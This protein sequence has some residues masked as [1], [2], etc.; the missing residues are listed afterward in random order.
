MIL[1]ISEK[2]IA[3]RRIA[4][5]L[6]NGNFKEKKESG[7][8]YF[9]FK[10][11]NKDFMV[12]P[13]SGHIMNVRFE[14]GFS[15]WSINTLEKLTNAKI[16][17]AG[18]QKRIIS[19]IKKKIPEADEII[20]ATDADRE[21][22]SIGFEVLR[23][24]DE[25]NKKI[26]IKRATFSAITKEDINAAFSDLGKVNENIASSADARREID[27]IW[28]AVLT[29]FL[30]VSSKR[31]GKSFLSAGRVQSPVLS[32][33]V[34]RE[35][36]R[37]AFKP[38]PYWEIEAEFEKDSKKFK[39]FHSHGKFSKQSEAQKVLKKKQKECIVDEIKKRK[40]ILKKPMPFN[41]TSFLAAATSIGF[42]AGKAMSAAES[43][44]QKGLTSYPRT[45]NAVY[46]KT[47]N[48]KKIVLMIS[49]INKLKSSAEKILSQKKIEPSRGKLSK[50]H[51]PIYPVGIPKQELSTEEWR[52]YELICRR[53]LATLSEDALT[54]NLL[55]KIL[56]KDELFTSS[57]QTF[58]KKGWKEVYPYSKATEIFLPKLKKGDKV[59]LLD[60]KLLSKETQPKPHYSQGSLLKLMAE[61]EL[62]T[63]S[64]RHSIIQKLYFRKY[65]YGSKAINANNVAFAVID[66]LEKFNSK[67]TEPEM[68]KELEREMDLISAGKKDKKQAVQE[69]RKML[70]M[71]LKELLANREKIS[72]T[73]RESL[74]NDKI[75]GSCTRKNCEGQLIIRKSRF[76]KR[77]LGC[78]TYPN[79]TQTHPL[80]P[81]GTII[82]LEKICE[83][84]Q[85]P[86]LKILGRRYSFEMCVDIE[87]NKKHRLKKKQKTA[88]AKTE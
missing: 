66:A 56:M 57:G 27:L 50:D 17:Y 62:G 1:I 29:R 45:D 73:I 82:T 68:T 42:S 58:V 4:E 44:Y 78:T 49:K 64:T 48:L 71:V 15:S 21:G 60:L 81:K 7:A 41:T 19:L 26:K 75:I 83:F 10:K 13:L 52:I 61:L 16:E 72:K 8:L 59:L 39:G 80:P 88:K 20:I 51:P 47:I 31:L 18:T 79:C 36:E 70:E 55:V 77:F 32:L 43:L 67:I 54:E 3:G 11:D 6:S 84:C 14:D 33:I 86:M 65:I 2:A 25:I 87:C 85:K 24:A 74:R 28:G 69:S 76:G 34:K 12:I 37:K 9:Y 23:I 22:E 46:P 38:T 5:I 63:K 35:N 30:S 53:F 40:R